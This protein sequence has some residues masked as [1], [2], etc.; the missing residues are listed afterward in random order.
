MEK[1][2]KKGSFVVL[3]VVIMV[4]FCRYQSQPDPLDTVNNTYI[5]TEDY[6]I[7]HGEADGPVITPNVGWQP[8]ECRIIWEAIATGYTDKGEWSKPDLTESWLKEA[9]EKGLF[10]QMECR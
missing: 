3:L 7:W 8:T 5:F 6:Q 4:V 1:M 9:R 10:V 2:G